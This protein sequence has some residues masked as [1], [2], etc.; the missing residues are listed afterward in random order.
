MAEPW[1]SVRCILRSPWTDGTFL[2]EERITIWRAASFEEA[3]E[4]A[5]RDA[6]EFARDVDAEYVG[7]A[8]AYHLAEARLGSGAEV[9]SLIRVSDLPTND[10]L[11]T[12]F[13]TGTERQKDI[14][15]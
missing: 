7:L 2:Y 13:D 4:R 9:F 11:S 6:R 15:G 3:V 10:Y 5:E 14:S 8:Q 1:Y 12:F